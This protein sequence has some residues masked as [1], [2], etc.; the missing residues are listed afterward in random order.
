MMVVWSNRT[1]NP[2]NKVNRWF[3]RA[4]MPSDK[5]RTFIGPLRALGRMNA[6]HGQSVKVALTFALSAIFDVDRGGRARSPDNIA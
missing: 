6:P 1:R 3:S 2:E 4:D 5:R